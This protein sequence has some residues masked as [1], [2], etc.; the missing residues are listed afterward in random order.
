MPRRASPRVTRLPAPGDPSATPHVESAVGHA[1]CTLDPVIHERLRLAIVA[2]L[3]VNPAVS[4]ADLKRS[5]GMTDGNLSVHARRLEEVGYIAR[6][7]VRRGEEV[8]THYRLTPAGRR[9]LDGYL[10][11]LEAVVHAVRHTP[12]PN[13][14][15]SHRFRGDGV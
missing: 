4:F 14:R 3:A 8:R 11:G 13:L 7:K 2:V 1:A 15:S 9:A 6:D 12:A 10:A 5:L